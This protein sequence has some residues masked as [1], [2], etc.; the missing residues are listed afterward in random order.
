MDISVT[1]RPSDRS[2]RKDALDILKVLAAD[3]RLMDILGYLPLAFVNI[4]RFS[5]I[6]IREEI[7]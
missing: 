5:E 3:D 6:A 2:V 4:E 7:W 1:V